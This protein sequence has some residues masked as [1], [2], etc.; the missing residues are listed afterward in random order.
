[1]AWAFFV[2]LRTYFISTYCTEIRS[3]WMDEAVARGRLVQPGY[4][5]DPLVRFA[6]QQ[7]TW[8]GPAMPEVD[9]VK[10]VKAAEIMEA[11]GYKTAQQ[12]TAELTGGDWEQN[13][14]QIGKEQR[15]RADNKVQDETQQN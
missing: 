3:A 9:Q 7:C 8:N 11:R 14:A 12:A 15:R 13:I 4:F 6:Y 5:S 10:A 1:M 2:Q